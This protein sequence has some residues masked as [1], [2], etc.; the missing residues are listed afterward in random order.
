MED[1]GIEI[2]FA[3]DTAVEDGWMDFSFI[4]CAQFKSN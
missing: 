3:E 2:F 1:I 4:D